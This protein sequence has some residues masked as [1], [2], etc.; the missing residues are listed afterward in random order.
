MTLKQK[1][2]VGKLL[3]VNP[4]WVP[5]AKAK[6]WREGCK[7]LRFNSTLQRYEMDTYFRPDWVD[8]HHKDDYSD[9]VLYMKIA[10]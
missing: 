4:R 5:A 2:A 7:V 1:S 3:I 6:K 9:I 10:D 8:T